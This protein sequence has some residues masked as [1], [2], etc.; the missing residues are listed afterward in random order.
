MRIIA[1][2]LVSC[3]TPGHGGFWLSPDR[4]NHLCTLFPGFDGYAPDQWLEEDL[5]WSLAALAW[6]ELFSAHAVRNA[7]RSIQS[8]GTIWPAD[9]AERHYMDGPKAWLTLGD[10]A[11]QKVLAIADQFDRSTL[12]LWERGSLST[13]RGGGWHVWFTRR[14]D[15][16]Q[17]EHRMVAMP[18]PNKVFYTDAELARFTPIP[19]AA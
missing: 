9:S 6:P 8:C 13:A 4:W 11:A 15:A 5:D 16:G 2:G 12:H 3:S 10:P 7:V 1:P 14:T 17:T 18:Y 19:I